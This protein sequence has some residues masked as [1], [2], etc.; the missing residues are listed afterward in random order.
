LLHIFT[1]Q[2]PQ[3]QDLRPWLEYNELESLGKMEHNL[4]AGTKMTQN[5][6]TTVLVC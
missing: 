4:E 2:D 5:R 6:P 1:D 3:T